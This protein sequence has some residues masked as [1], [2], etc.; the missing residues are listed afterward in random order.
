MY[1]YGRADTVIPLEDGSGYTVMIW[2]DGS[3][4]PMT[5]MVD[6]KWEVCVFKTLH[7][8]DME[9]SNYN[10]FSWEDEEGEQ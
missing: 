6:G 5:T 7:Q 1:R 2:E 4:V 8:A 9:M 10:A 3:C